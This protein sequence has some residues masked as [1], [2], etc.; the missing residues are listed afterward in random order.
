MAKG[1]NGGKFMDNAVG[2][3]SYKSNPMKAPNM[4]KTMVG[5]GMNADQAK[6]NK[7]LQRAQ[8]EVDSL[9]GKGVM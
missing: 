3:N 1:S 9:R 2:M 5:P 7:L 6:A 8:R 4:N